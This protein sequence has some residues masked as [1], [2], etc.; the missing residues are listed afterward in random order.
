MC[1]MLGRTAYY[2]N[3]RVRITNP[4][5]NKDRTSTL[6][7]H[8]NR[9]AVNEVTGTWR[10]RYL[11]LNEKGTHY[12]IHWVTL[13][14]E[15]TSYNQAEV[16]SERIYTKMLL[17]G[18]QHAQPRKTKT[19]HKV[20]QKKALVNKDMYLNKTYVK[21]VVWEIKINGV[22]VGRSSSKMAARVIRDE[23]L[24]RQEVN[25]CAVCGKRPERKRRSHNQCD[26][27]HKERGCTNHILLRDDNY[28][29]KERE[30]WW[31]S[32]FW[33][34]DHGYSGRVGRTEV[35]AIRWERNP[36][37]LAKQKEVEEF[38]V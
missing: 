1:E 14:P 16:E 18:A 38:E 21:N 31:N 26:L 12:K 24:A 4:E 22:R 37:A 9:I 13:P 28:T 30:N 3:P 7:P 27:V 15:I 10:V 20:R 19:D 5:M 33:K 8:D 6:I 35:D 11:K 32:F 25:P 29:L 23:F 2:P 34:G 36:T 17:E